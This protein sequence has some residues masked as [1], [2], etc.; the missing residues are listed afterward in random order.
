MEKIKKDQWIIGGV[1]LF[2]IAMIA[3]GLIKDKVEQDALDSVEI[4]FDNFPSNNV[5]DTSYFVL[6]GRINDPTIN[7][8]VAL[9]KLLSYSNGNFK[10]L[11]ER[12]N[13]EAEGLLDI[14]LLKG[15]SF[16]NF[17]KKYI[18]KFNRATKEYLAK[19]KIQELKK[20][21]EEERAEFNR[22][23]KIFGKKAGKIKTRHPEWSW[24]DCHNV[25]ESKIWIGMDIEMLIYIRGRDFSRNVSNYGDGNQYQYCWMDYTP[26]CF[27]DND[28]DGKI[29]SYN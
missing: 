28:G 25:A 23:I 19:L 2:A 17:Q 15:N 3:F 8:N 14:N 27:Y 5:I 12:R 24:E 20:Q 29:E 18:V 10:I 22:K 11:I 16:R 26:S 4:K 9:G 6:S 13:D 7:L 21:K 1:I